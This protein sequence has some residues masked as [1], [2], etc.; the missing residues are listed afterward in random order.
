MSDDNLPSNGYTLDT[1][2]DHLNYA[3]YLAEETDD[4]K[5]KYHLREAHQKLVVLEEN[6]DLKES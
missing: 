2:Q 1:L 4:D 6:S 3:Y 5:I